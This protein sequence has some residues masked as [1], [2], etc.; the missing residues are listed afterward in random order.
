MKTPKLPKWA[1]YMT[2]L[3]GV[4]KM[5]PLSDALRVELLAG[6]KAAGKPKRAAYHMGRVVNIL[7]NLDTY[8]WQPMFEWAQMTDFERRFKQKKTPLQ[9]AMARKKRAKSKS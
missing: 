7:F 5:Q 8:F 2:I 9:K 6:Q 1:E 3:E 4:E